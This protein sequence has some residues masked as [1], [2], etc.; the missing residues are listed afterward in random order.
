MNVT[1]NTFSGRVKAVTTANVMAEL[2]IETGGEPRE[3]V[4][5]VPR[6]M[7]EGLNI[8][9]GDSV[10]ALVNPADVIVSKG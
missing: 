1:A 4:A 9:V 8:R 10:T 3:L 2:V 6:S 7:V 5:V